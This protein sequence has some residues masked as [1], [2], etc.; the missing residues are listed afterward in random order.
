[1]AAALLALA[2]PG[3]KEA[4]AGAVAAIVLMAGSGA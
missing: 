2:I 3:L 1:V 4:S